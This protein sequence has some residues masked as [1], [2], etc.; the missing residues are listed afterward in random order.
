M[1]GQSKRST[2][3]KQPYIIEMAGVA[4][5]GKSTLLKAM[6]QKNNKIQTVHLPLKIFYLPFLIKVICTWLPLYLK[7]Y[8][9]SRWF[10]LQEIRDMGYLET[11]I[12]FIRS[13]AQTKENIVVIDPGSVYWLSSLQEYG[14]EITKHPRFQ[15]W[16][17]NRFE[18][19]SSALDV[20]IWIDAPEEMCLQRVLSRNEWHEI[21][22]IS[23]KSALEQLSG[24]RKA[25]ER[26]IPEMA[27]QHPIKV[28]S[29]RS[30]QISTEEMVNRIGSEIDLMGNKTS[31]P[32]S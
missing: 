13:Q 9:H 2:N 8:R 27:S 23:A 1:I 6:K 30:D 14:P 15:R 28:F 4:G 11:W 17:K 25:Y 21:K 16:W 29:F 31:L 5:A 22:Y 26:I 20:I 3:N 32:V 19:W 10:T 12:S 24:F 7:D 18:Q